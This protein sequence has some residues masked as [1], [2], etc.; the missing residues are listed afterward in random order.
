[1][2]VPPEH[3]K[4]LERLAQGFF[5]SSSHGCDAFLRHK[6][7]LISPSILKKYGIPFDKVTQEAGEFMITFPY[8]YH[9]GFNHG[10]NCAESTNFATFRWIDYGKAA[11][12][13]NWRTNSCQYQLP[14]YARGKANKRHKKQPVQGRK[15]KNH[16][17]YCTG[18]HLNKS[19]YYVNQGNRVKKRKKSISNNSFPHTRSR[20][21]KL[22]TPEDKRVSAVVAGAEITATEAATDGFKVSKEP[23]KKVRLVNTEVPSGGEDDSGRMQLDQHLLD[24]VKVAGEI[25]T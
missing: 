9:A 3:G 5:P 23:G 1:Y 18:E 16:C 17:T 20:S 25:R 6:M 24:N 19:Y 13:L 7:T 2:A 4:R 21:K 15:M 8:G 10:F 12:L 11:K 22:K 14:L